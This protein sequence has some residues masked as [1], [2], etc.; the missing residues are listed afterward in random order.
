MSDHDLATLARANPVPP[1]RVA[2]EARSAWGE[3]TL[4]RIAS[5]ALRPPRRRRWMPLA[6]GAGSL[7]VLAAAFVVLVVATGGGGTPA[8]SGGDTVTVTLQ[9]PP[10]T[11]DAA[12][13]LAAAKAGLPRRAERLGIPIQVHAAGATLDVTLPRDQQDRLTDLIA[14]GDLAVYSERAA[15]DPQGT[16]SKADAE[17]TA[18]PGDRLVAA[19]AS[20][21]ARVG[22]PVFYVFRGRPAMTG[23]DVAGTQGLDG[24]VFLKLTPAGRTAFTRLTRQAAQDGALSNRVRWIAI[25]L[26]DRLLSTAAIDYRQFPVG[27]DGRNGIGFDDEPGRDA[28][29]AAQIMTPLPALQVAPAPGSG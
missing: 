14:P 1:G 20:T 8:T 6:A 7:S 17:A 13:L 5:G 26:D 11:A 3:A 21:P 27:I 9:V 15:R 22:A 29:I 28:V 4:E 24:Q 12:A 10:G 18:R 16:P 19:Q 23:A 25:V 2:G